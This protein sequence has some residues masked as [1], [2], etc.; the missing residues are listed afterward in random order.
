MSASEEENKAVSPSISFTFYSEN[1]GGRL[2]L[3]SPV[4]LNLLSFLLRPALNSSTSCLWSVIFDVTEDE[5]ATDRNRWN[6][7]V[8]FFL[9]SVMLKEKSRRSSSSWEPTHTHTHS[10]SLNR[11]D[12]VRCEEFYRAAEM[13]NVPAE[14]DNVGA[15][16]PSLSSW[17]NLLEPPGAEWQ[18]PWLLLWLSCWWLRIQCTVSDNVFFFL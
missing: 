12:S 16:D 3:W 18:Q 17:E 10:T 7:F 13:K 1:P 2:W 8:R 11:A 4:P 15:V 9:R 6:T 14:V 5:K